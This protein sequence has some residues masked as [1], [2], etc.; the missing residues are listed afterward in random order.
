MEAMRRT[1]NAR[2]TQGTL[3]GQE[4]GASGS[5]FTVAVS[6]QL[7]DSVLLFPDFAED[8]GVNRLMGWIAETMRS[9]ATKKE[10]LQLKLLFRASRDGWKAQDF[11]RCC[12]KQGPTVTVIRSESGHVFGGVT[13]VSWSSSIGW[14][15]SN[16]FLFGLRTHANGSEPVRFLLISGKEDKSTRHETRWGPRFGEGA[17][18]C[19]NR[20][21]NAYPSSRQD[22]GSTFDAGGAGRFPF[23][24]TECF[25]IADWEV[26]QIIC[27]SAP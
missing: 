19:V 18:L 27:P 26:L 8:R 12:D 13:D 21:A 20:D 25:K 2:L 9:F 6:P 23:T 24:G 7:C 16:A 17:N 4:G 14:R 10:E 1:E 5:T 11:H 15:K 3:L 22:V